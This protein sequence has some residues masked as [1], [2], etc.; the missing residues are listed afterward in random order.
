MKNKQ[1]WHFIGLGEYAYKFFT[2]CSNKLNFDSYTLVTANLPIAHAPSTEFIF[3]PERKYLPASIAISYLP[4]RLKEILQSTEGEVIIL[5]GLGFGS[6]LSLFEALGMYCR[7]LPNN[8]RFKFISTISP[9]KEGRPFPYDFANEAVL[10]ISDQFSQKS[11]NTTS[12]DHRLWIYKTDPK[13]WRVD[14]WVVWA[15]NDFMQNH[16]Q[17]GVRRHF[18]GFGL[19]A[20]DYFLSHASELKFDSFTLVNAFEPK[21]S[22]VPF[23]YFYTPEYEQFAAL[24]AGKRMPEELVALYSSLE[25]EIIFFAGLGSGSGEGLMS[26]S[27]R[28]CSY[29]AAPGRFKFVSVR[30]TD[31]KKNDG[32]AG[33]VLDIM[34][35]FNQRSF[36]MSYLPLISGQ[37]NEQTQ[38]E[39]LTT[40]IGQALNSI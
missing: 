1:Q 11:L 3:F 40:W 19:F 7:S 28:L 33:V 27:V 34:E 4:H 9:A 17:V 2:R 26:H 38:E 39:V 29:L 5:A 35:E 10:N 24:F 12:I 18:I 6:G 13:L 15:I 37:S 25:G 16:G 22:E 21:K 14:G 36:D 23:R 8:G 30:S 20:T 31:K 32:G